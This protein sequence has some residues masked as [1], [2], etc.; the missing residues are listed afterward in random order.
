MPVDFVPHSAS[1]RRSAG[2]RSVRYW[3]AFH[4]NFGPL[5]PGASRRIPMA[6]R[7]LVLGCWIGLWGVCAESGGMAGTNASGASPPPPSARIT[8]VARDEPLGSVLQRISKSS[9]VEI[10]VADEWLRGFP[11]TTTLSNV[12]LE[13]CLKTVLGNLDYALESQKERGQVS[14]IVIR[15]RDRGG[16]GILTGFPAKAG[17]PP[18]V[19]RGGTD[20][21]ETAQGIVSLGTGEVIP[22]NRRG[23][24]GIT[25]AEIDAV[26][27]A[28][29][30]AG[31]NAVQ[32][33]PPAELIRAP[34]PSGSRAPGD[35]ERRR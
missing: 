7:G 4:S 16:E 31:S 17:V 33:L 5:M 2:I 35:L 28:R 25:Q 12:T 18:L 22:P 8:L 20:E 34:E 19:V 30:S 1:C 32:L 10:V 3:F 11:L 23:E 29:R 15:V 24:K 13:V 21:V 14:R 26:V 9:H 6:C 27:A